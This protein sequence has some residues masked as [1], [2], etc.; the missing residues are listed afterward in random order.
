MASRSLGSLTVDLILK[1]GGFKQGADAAAREIDSAE[2]RI[3]A[4]TKKI[5][6]SFRNMGRL[7]AGA[8][9]GLGLAQVIRATAEAEQAFAALTNAVKNN[10]G[11]V[12]RTAE[13]LAEAATEL[14]SVTTFSDDAIQSMQALL[15]KFSSIRG[16]EFDRATQSTLDLAA[17]LGT[18][19]PAAAKLIGRA[20][21]DPIAGLSRL[22]RAGIIFSAQQKRVIEGLVNTGKSAE[23]QRVILD[24]LDAKVKGSAAAMRNNFGGALT[25]LKNAFGDLLE[26][27]DGIPA[28][29]EAINDL[30]DALSNPETK[31]AAD[32][33][34]GALARMGAVAVQGL[35]APIGF[36]DRLGNSFE[37]T[38]A[39]IEKGL[40]LDIPPEVEQRLFSTESKI[41]SITERI[42][43][44]QE[45]DQRQGTGGFN[46]FNRIE[47]GLLEKRLSTLR[48]IAIVEAESRSRLSGPSNPRGRSQVLSAPSEEN[49]DAIDKIV[50]QTKSATQKYN[51]AIDELKRLQKLSPEDI[52]PEVFA[53]R[54]K[55]LKEELNKPVKIGTSDTQREVNSARESVERF[56]QQLIEQRDTLGLT[57][58][59]SLRYSITQ[60]E[61]ARSLDKLGASAEPLREKLLGLADAVG[62]GQATQQ[63]TQQIEDQIRTLETQAATFG[64]TEQQAFAYS[65]TQGE[66]AKSL[67]QMKEGAEEATVRL[68]ELNNQQA[69]T[70]AEMERR[71]EETSIFE[72]T[73]TDAEKYVASLERLNEVF[74]GSSDQETYGRAVADAAGE[75][76][77]ASSAAEEYRLV[78]EELSKKLSENPEALA[79]AVERATETLHKSKDEMTVFM[80]QAARN[81]QDILANFLENPFKDGLK[82]MLASFG[83]M[84]RQMAAQAVAAQIASKIF[85][86]AAGGTGTGILGGIGKFFGFAGGGY[87]GDGGKYEPAGVVHK[88]EGVLSQREIRSIGGPSGFQSLRESINRFGAD[89]LH[90][91]PL[92]G[93][94]E[95]GMVGAVP[96]YAGYGSAAMKGVDRTGSMT[97][98]QNFT[99]SAPGGTVSR[100]TEAQIAAAASRGLTTATRR[101]S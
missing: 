20:L 86:S 41:K 12:G 59:Q 32:S 66:I 6:D 16:D 80:E 50:E 45:I 93:Y 100:A 37:R 26:G 9:A 18:D 34:I 94:A 14:Q 31:R 68:L 82:G 27:K 25:G 53:T 75:Y 1:M 17:A 78:L 48:E 47:V 97:V 64:L 49:L 57:E 67:S 92:P 101:N 71:S 43:F 13:Q 60:G 38:Q 84:L 11:A 58:T 8:F 21:E 5:Q 42:A 76:I 15:L 56:T 52:T 81:T 98:T 95:G 29:T 33:L 70:R 35:S 63:A 77:E 89:F 51:E 30:T 22:A 85:G 3:S 40:G 83:D 19:L 96:S 36:L 90:T 74:A 69:A 46:T 72:A 99:V 88:G 24:A 55:Q 79:A 65:V 91:L 4:R 39:R 28:A 61:I 54:V 87:T 2:R 62:D 10:G 73:R 7:F 44:L 23:A